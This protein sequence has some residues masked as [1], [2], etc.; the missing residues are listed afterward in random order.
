MESKTKEKV[1]KKM[2]GT[3]SS[4]IARR[5]ERAID[6]TLVEVGKV[7]D[8]W[9]YLGTAIE[10]KKDTNRKVY[11]IGRKDIKELKQKLGIK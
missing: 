5:T 3:D 8:D 9:N 6:L 4:T 1:L 2:Y 10:G 7:I 11:R